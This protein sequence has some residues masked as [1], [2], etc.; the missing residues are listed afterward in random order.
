MKQCV[1]MC[2]Y[3][4]VCMSVCVR[5]CV[6]TS[7][8]LSHTWLI[9]REVW[10]K[11][12]S[13][14]ILIISVPLLFH[15]LILFQHMSEMAPSDLNLPGKYFATSPAL[16]SYIGWKMSPLLGAVRKIRLV[17]CSYLLWRK[18]TKI[19]GVRNFHINSY[20]R[21]TKDIIG[22]SLTNFSMF[23]HFLHRN[24][25]RLV[26]SSLLVSN[27][28]SQLVGVHDIIAIPD[29]NCP[30]KFTLK[31]TYHAGNVSRNGI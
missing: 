27:N 23:V 20:T 2:V 15:I 21:S 3:V 14:F 8:F 24:S 4:C 9:E 10:D 11:I 26:I 17:L 13:F 6:Q 22:I 16:V 28:D 19:T 31:M 1:C 25:Y 29:S 12:L 30:T 5:V 7:I 18:Y